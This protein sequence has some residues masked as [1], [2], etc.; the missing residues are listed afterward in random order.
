MAG[1]S[2]DGA[3]E[4]T[5]RTEGVA[6]REDSAAAAEDA[7]PG[8][9]GAPA[10]GPDEGAGVFCNECGWENPPGANFCSRCGH[11]LQS[12]AGHSTAGDDASDTPPGTKPAAGPPA[13][14]NATPAGNMPAD[15]TP[16]DEPAPGNDPASGRSM[17]QRVALVVTVAALV[18]GGLY[19][20]S[21][22]SSGGASSG[23]GD[24]G[25]T[26]APAS[27]TAEGGSGAPPMMGGG[28]TSPG[29]G[30]GNAGGDATRS[31]EV[32]ALIQDQQSGEF[33]AVI[34]ARADSLRNIV[35]TRGG[36]RKRLARRQLGS[37]FAKE[38]LTKRAAAQQWRLAQE[39]GDDLRAW[40]QAGALL[41]EWMLSLSRQEQAGERLKV[42]RLVT[43]VYQR[44]LEREPENYDVRTHL[45]V[46][47]TETNRPMRGISE[48]KR[49]LNEAP[50]HAGARFNYGLMQMMVSRY[51]T[52]IEQF[53]RVRE[54]AGAD[55]EYYQR[56]GALIERINQETNGNPEDA[57]MPGQGDSGGG[58][59]PGG[60]PSAGTTGS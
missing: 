42:A 23:G 19:G 35:E 47:Y 5:A 10:S 28:G 58:S 8:G 51:A 53:E 24:A 14:G 7:V 13:A 52:A 37:L 11:A 50:D 43:D 60:P 29:G 30:G 38:G 57:P 15:S 17:A 16:A 40:E 48:L 45:A 49:V 39:A 26:A 44:V 12:L 18:V 54:V 56:A 9:D 36:R 41:Y 22:W 59:A 55:S 4:E 2:P 34:A 27:A 25:S 6:S 31:G 33:P 46:A 3:E 21:A 32:P 20:W 1:A